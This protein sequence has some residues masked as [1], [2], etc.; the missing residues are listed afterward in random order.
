MFTKMQIPSVMG[1][2]TPPLKIETVHMNNVGTNI[3]TLTEEPKSFMYFHNKHATY[4]FYGDVI[5]DVQT[6]TYYFIGY[7]GNYGQGASDISINGTS[8]S[9]NC[10]G[11]FSGYDIEIYYI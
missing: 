1:G 3:F 10:S 4:K 9:V 7:A 8:I 5:Y 2:G 6:D 11:C